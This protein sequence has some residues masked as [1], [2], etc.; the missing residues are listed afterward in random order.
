MATEEQWQAIVGNEGTYD[1]VFYYAVETTGIY[2]RPSCKSK[3]PN[4]SN[5]RI[6]A[7]ASAAEAEG[8]RP[9]KR[10]RPQG[11]RLPDEEWV[12]QIVRYIDR[13]YAERLTL[14]ELADR[15]HGSRFHLQR[16]FKR[17]KGVSPMEYVQQVRMD[18]ASE[19][20]V[21]TGES[22]LEIAQAVGIGGAAY[23]TTLFKRKTGLTPGAYRE[24]IWQDRRHAETS[25]GA[26][27]ANPA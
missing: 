4:R 1:G 2:C 19:R 21:T 17:I 15:C 6:F 20:L 13:H 26:D 7:D 16:T 10:C 12:E 5:V 18:Q 23:L 27:S 22:V 8:F 14:E 9:C 25:E 24:R 11:V 3:A